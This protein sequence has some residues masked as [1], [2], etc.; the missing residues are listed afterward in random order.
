LPP[1]AAASTVV[2]KH[3][4]IR[5]AHFAGTRWLSI[6]S[7]IQPRIF[8]ASSWDAPRLSLGPAETI[9]TAWSRSWLEE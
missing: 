6:K 2:L 1:T 7:P 5:A 4:P 9:Q 8:A 3:C